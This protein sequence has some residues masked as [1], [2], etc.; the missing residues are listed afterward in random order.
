MKR[1]KPKGLSGIGKGETPRNLW[2]IAKLTL[3]PDEVQRFSK[4]SHVATDVGRGRAWLR[5]A[6]NERTLENY[7]HILLAEE[8]NLK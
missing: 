5:A 1:S 8:D 6:I 3:S 4:L 7:L 2:T